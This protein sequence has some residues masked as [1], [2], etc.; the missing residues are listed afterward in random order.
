[1]GI[2]C[3]HGEGRAHFPDPQ[4]KQTVLEEGLAPIRFT[5]A[6]RFSLLLLHLVSTITCK[7]PCA[8][9]FVTSRTRQTP[10]HGYGA[11]QKVIEACIHAFSCTSM[12]GHFQPHQLHP[13]HTC[14]SATAAHGKAWDVFGGWMLLIYC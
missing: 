1:M 3:A 13:K 10:G 12:F 7:L 5:T 2:W 11:V 9:Q 6:H 14:S 8:W 4:V